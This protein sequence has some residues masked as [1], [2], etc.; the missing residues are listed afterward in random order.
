MDDSQFYSLIDDTGMV[1]AS[2]AERRP[3][4]PRGFRQTI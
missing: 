3:D 4:S 2:K 1:A